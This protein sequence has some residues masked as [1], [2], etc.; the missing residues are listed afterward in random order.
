[1]ELLETSLSSKRMLCDWQR[2]RQVQANEVEETTD[3]SKNGGCGAITLENLI[4]CG[5]RSFVL[6]AECKCCPVCMF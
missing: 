4:G 1:M 5:V 6:M 2:D 3:K